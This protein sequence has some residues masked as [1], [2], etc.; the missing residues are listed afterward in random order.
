M[1]DRA[2]CLVYDWD[3]NHLGHEIL[4][5]TPKE[6]A[7]MPMGKRDAYSLAVA[8]KF[9]SLTDHVHVAILIVD[10][11]GEFPVAIATKHLRSRWNSGPANSHTQTWLDSGGNIVGYNVLKKG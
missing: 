11:E 2:V 1:T 3:W 7:E 8:K 10:W 4:F 5:L 9:T 6:V